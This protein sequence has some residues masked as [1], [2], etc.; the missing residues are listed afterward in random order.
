MPLKCKKCGAI[1]PIAGR[2]SEEKKPQDFSGDP[3]ITRV[4]IEK[5]ICPHCESIELEEVH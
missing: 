5:P 3:N 1:F 4:I 2:K